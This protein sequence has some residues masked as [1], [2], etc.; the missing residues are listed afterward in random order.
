MQVQFVR[1]LEMTGPEV[2][3]EVR[4][5]VDENPA[6]EVN[7]RVG[8]LPGDEQG[9]ASFNESAEDM[10]L[11]D[12]R[13]EDDIPSYRLEAR[14]HSVNDTYYEPVAVASGDTIIDTLSSQLSEYELTEKQ[15]IIADYIIGNLDDNGYL[16]RDVMAM[17]DDLTFNVGLDVDMAEVREVFEVVRSLEPAGIA[18]I[19]LRDCLLLQLKRKDSSKWVAVAR[20]V[21]ANY[22]DLFSKMHYDKLCSSLGCC[23]SHSG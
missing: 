8:N 20:D 1:M 17:C 22:F 9:D 6:L 13:N 23:G 14:N 7:D 11:A 12:Y 5:A 21:I 19:D 3:D 16:T 15:L 18:A 2:E 10:Q 4:R